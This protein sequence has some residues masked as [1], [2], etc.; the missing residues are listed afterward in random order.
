ME[1]KI[2]RGSE[3]ANRWVIWVLHLHRATTVLPC[4]LVMLLDD[5]LKLYRLKN[6]SVTELTIDQMQVA[7][8]VVAKHLGRRP[9]LLDITCT[10]ISAFLRA[11]R[12]SARTANNKRAVLITLWRFAVGEKLKVR[13]LEEVPKLKVSKNIPRAWSLAQFSKL[14]NATIMLNGMIGPHKESVWMRALLFVCFSTA[15]RIG[16]VMKI[17]MED[18]DLDTGMVVVYEPKTSKEQVHRLTPQAILAV[19]AIIHPKRDF[20]FGDWPFDPQPHRWTTLARRLKRL[21]DSADVPNIGRF[22][23]IRRTS[24]TL[25]YNQD[26]LAAQRMLGH[27][28]II[29]TE[30]HYIDTTK[31]TLPVPSDLLPS[32]AL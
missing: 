8:N 12:G 20:L 6:P 32:L 23:A 16:A 26:R 24:A 7:I 3:V 1:R 9:T 31:L 30:N 5:L 25:V 18:L 14:I 11:Y 27:S 19:K 29:M 10:M 21:M 15:S 28:S 17:R 22:H 4:G 13:N 2:P